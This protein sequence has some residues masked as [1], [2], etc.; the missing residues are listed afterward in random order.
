MP[1]LESNSSVWREGWDWSRG[2]DEWSDWWGGTDVMWR[3]AWWPRLQAFLP[4][5][6]VL[7]IA[8]GFGRWTHYLKDLAHELVVVDLTEQCI[9]HCKERFSASSHI[10][11]HVND[12]RSLEMLDDES[13]DVVVSL[14]SLVHSEPSVL[15]GYVRQLAAKLTADGVGVLHH[16]NAG[17]YRR[18]SDITKRVPTPM[19][20]RWVQRG[21][22]PDV[23]A[24][25]DDDMTAE[26]F[27]EHCERAGLACIGQEK[28]S[29]ERGRYLTDALSIFT[30]PG[31][32]WYRPL[33]VVEN[34]GFSDEGRRMRT[35]WSPST[36][37]L[38]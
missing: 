5:G 29:W 23:N 4:A 7:E 21:F 6:R 15:E 26:L 1:D 13:I 32:R 11:Y 8:P 25:R 28:L 38:A 18:L 30:R 34:P 37:R 3:G 22:L 14:D 19:R 10:T 27:V 17:H 12:G 33:S 16:S 31:S 2:G 20:Q 9:D 36:F 24:W 35:V